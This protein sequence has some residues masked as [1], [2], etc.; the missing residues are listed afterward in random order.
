MSQH[1]QTYWQKRCKTTVVQ[2]KTPIGIVNGHGHAEGQKETLCG[3]RGRGSRRSPYPLGAA[4]NG[5]RTGKVPNR[6]QNVVYRHT[7]QEAVIGVPTFGY[8]CGPIRQYFDQNPHGTAYTKCR[9]EFGN[10]GEHNL[11]PLAPRHGGGGA[12]ESG[13]W[14]CDCGLMMIRTTTIERVL[15]RLPSLFSSYKVL[16]TEVGWLT[17]AT[18][19]LTLGVPTGSHEAWRCFGRA[20]KERTYGSF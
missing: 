20:A 11:L 16:S 13:D 5:P 9:T 19:W 18:F 15:R 7:Q 3:A 2:S 14:L 6:L 8:P 4:G 1:N 10:H 12:G 17:L